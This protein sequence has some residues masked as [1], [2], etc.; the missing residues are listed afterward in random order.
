MPNSYMLIGVAISALLWRNVGR[1]VLS[2]TLGR[3]LPVVDSD[4]TTASCATSGSAR[5]SR[6]IDNMSDVSFINVTLLLCR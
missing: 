2:G 3:V 5:S 4:V 6:E 1:R